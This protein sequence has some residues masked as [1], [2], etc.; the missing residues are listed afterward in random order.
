MEA[1]FVKGE[2]WQGLFIDGDLRLE[3]H[4][5]ETI[6]VLK[7]IAWSWRDGYKLS[8]KVYEVNQDWLEDE[9]NFPNKFSAIPV[10]Q[11]EFVEEVAF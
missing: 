7:E 8:V 10:N 3:E 1:K 2:D 6:D 9:G 5:L 11:I 4:E